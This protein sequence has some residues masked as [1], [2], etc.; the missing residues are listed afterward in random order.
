[1]ALYMS[2]G[3]VVTDDRLLDYI[4]KHLCFLYKPSTQD[5]AISEIEPEVTVKGAAFRLTLPTTW[6]DGR[7]IWHL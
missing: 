3:R 5:G 1:M 7:R 4:W 2:K 6:R